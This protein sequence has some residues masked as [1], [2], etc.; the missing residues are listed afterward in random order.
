M[1]AFFPSSQL[2]LLNSN[3]FCNSFPRSKLRHRK[4]DLHFFFNKF[5]ALIKNQAGM[6]SLFVQLLNVARFCGRYG[7]NQ[8]LAYGPA[9]G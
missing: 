4:A 7:F 6:I 2:S 1:F 5:S 8:L 9:F 3:A